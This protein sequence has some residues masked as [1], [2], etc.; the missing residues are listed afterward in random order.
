VSKQNRKSSADVIATADEQQATRPARVPTI[1][2]QEILELKAQQDELRAKIRLLRARKREARSS[3]KDAREARR[4]A[5]IGK[6][7]RHDTRSHARTVAVLQVAWSANPDSFTE[8]VAD[9]GY[10]LDK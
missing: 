1:E 5:G 4:V 3:V 7:L 9:L 2:E 8:A 10:S 6:W